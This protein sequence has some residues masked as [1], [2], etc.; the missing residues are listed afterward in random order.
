LLPLAIMDSGRVKMII[1]STTFL[2]GHFLTNMVQGQIQNK[3]EYEYTKTKSSMTGFALL[4]Y[5]FNSTDDVRNSI[6]IRGVDDSLNADNI[7]E[8]QLNTD[9]MRLYEISGMQIA[10]DSEAFF[11]G[12][13]YSRDYNLDSQESKKNVISRK[14]SDGVIELMKIHT[15]QQGR[16]YVNDW[17][18]NSRVMVSDSLIKTIYISNSDFWVN[19]E[20]EKRRLVNKFKFTRAIAETLTGVALTAALAWSFR[21]R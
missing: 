12:T 7:M 9:S 3:I 10:N 18:Y 6:M 14:N 19:N 11:V 15:D 1:V 2:L 4:S 20:R 21:A 8:I 5:V 16:R 13:W 17:R